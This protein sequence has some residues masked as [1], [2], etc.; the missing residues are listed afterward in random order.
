MKKLT[1]SAFFIVILS[2]GVSAFD[3][4]DECNTGTGLS[5]NPYEEHCPAIAVG[6][7]CCAWFQ[8]WHVH[9][10]GQLLTTDGITLTTYFMNGNSA[11]CSAYGIVYVSENIDGPWTFI[12]N[13]PPA[14]AGYNEVSETFNDIDTDFR[15]VKVQTSGQCNV[16]YSAAGVYVPEPEV[17][18][19][20]TIAAGIALVG[21][22]A[23]MLLL[24]KR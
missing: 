24:R 15:Y 9:D 5:S 3:F 23:G 17:P 14:P 7:D 6:K 11:T 16:D 12:G 20:T 2:I 10:M 13:M 8:D 4:Y 21:A 18:E 19:F 1:L 22:V